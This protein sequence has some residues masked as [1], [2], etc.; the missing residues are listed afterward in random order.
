MFARRQLLEHVLV[1]GA[2]GRIARASLLSTAR[3]SAPCAR[4]RISNSERSDF[5]K[6]ASN[7]PAQP[8][9]TSTSCFVG[10]KISSAG[11]RR[12]TFAAD[13]SS[14]P[15]C[16]RAARGGCASH[17]RYSG[18]VAVR[19]QTAAR[20]DDER[21][22]LDA[23]R[24]LVLAG[25]A[26]RAL[27]QHLLACRSRR[28]WCR[29]RQPAGRPASAEI[30]V[31]GFSS[32]PAPHAGQFTWQRPHSTQ[33]NASSTRLAAEVLHGL[34]PD[35]LLLEIEVRHARRARATSGTR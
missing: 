9:Q 17:R 5:W 34:Q 31:L 14:G 13:R 21:Q 11:R 1:A 16:S 29:A 20:A 33:V 6:S 4:V 10:S 15:R 25:A 23:D 2:L 24:A 18:R 7:A 22:V 30:S 12:R 3:R 32:L 8:S 27:P 35:L 28:V 26:R 19:H